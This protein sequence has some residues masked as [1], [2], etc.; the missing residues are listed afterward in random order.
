MRINF[1]DRTAFPVFFLILLL[2][3]AGCTKKPNGDQHP[4]GKPAIV[5]LAPSLTEMIFAIGAGDQLVGRT[6]ACDWPAAA[7][8]VSV[9]GA[10]GRPS[11]ELLASIHPDLV[12]DVDLADEEMGKKIS[13][14][15][16]QQES[17]PCKSPDDIPAALRKLGKL[18]GHSREADSLALSIS[19]GLAIFNKTAQNLKSR[20]LLP[21]PS[22]RP[23]RR[24]R[25]RR[26]STI[27]ASGLS[28]SRRW[29]ITTP[30]SLRG[31][32]RE[33]LTCCLSKRSSIP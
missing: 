1:R 19:K 15:G 23:A 27:P 21:A 4:A 5:S 25:S 14:L 3:A 18:T 28:P 10:F 7:A 30:S 9:V 24:F 2:L 16:I 29:L 22:A 12:V 26:M 13:A 31:L 8:K 20:V 11:L 17:I 33:A 32:W 6:S